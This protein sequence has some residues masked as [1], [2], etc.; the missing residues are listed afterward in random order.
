MLR[1]KAWLVVM[2]NAMRDYLDVVALAHRIGP[3]APAVIAAMDDYYADQLGAGGA[4]VAT[5]V[6][7]QL[8]DPL[9]Y[10]LSEIDLRH[11]RQL[12]PRWRDWP[13]V[14]DACRDLAAG[15]LDAVARA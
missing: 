4:R 15:V 1:I 3:T 13:A 10:D 12:E 7:R 8:A 9:P 11:Y 6:A 14:S 2:R 5:Q